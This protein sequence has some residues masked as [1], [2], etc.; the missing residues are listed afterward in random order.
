MIPL[1]HQQYVLEKMPGKGGWTYAVIEGIPKD[2]RAKFGCVQVNGSIDGFELKNY[3]LM[4]MANGKLFLPVRAEI[5]KKIN[6][7]AG[8]SVQVILYL[9]DST[10]VF[11]EEI[12]ACL[13]DEPEAYKIF[14]TYPES[15]QKRMIDWIILAKKDEIKVERI[16]ELIDKLLRD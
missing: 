5:R 16:V 10:T 14:I 8:E 6:K 11:P 1:V 2:K 4:P 3:K 13:K 15:E 7:N 12:I 9:D